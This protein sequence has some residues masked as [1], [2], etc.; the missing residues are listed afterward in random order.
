MQTTSPDDLRIEANY[1]QLYAAIGAALTM[2]AIASLALWW[3][4]GDLLQV[5]GLLASF[6]G[7]WGLI[8][9]LIGLKAHHEIRRD[10]ADAESLFAGAAWADWQWS[11]SEWREQIALRRA[12]VEQ[13]LRFQRFAPW[14]GVIAGVVIGGSILALAVIGGDAMPSEV[15]GFLVVLAIGFACLSVLITLSGVWRERRKWRARLARAEAAIAPRLRFGPY[16]F[17]H[18]ADGHTSLRRLH[19]VGFSRQ[20]N[21]LTFQ[22]RYATS[23]GGTI[24]HT[25]NTPVPA[26]HAADAEALVRRYRSERQ[27]RG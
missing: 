4:G 8:I 7:I 11:P 5:A 18:D 21:A 2:L 16:G 25:I 9:T 19:N 3:M 14:I 20:H 6:G 17:Y 23:R 15:R 10:R 24:Y 22:L 1:H 26:A 27:L 13:Q 12:E